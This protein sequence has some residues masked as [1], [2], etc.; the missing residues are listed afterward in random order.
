LRANAASAAI[1][2]TATS[3]HSPPRSDK[4]ENYDIASK[5]GMAFIIEE[6]GG[7]ATDGKQDLMSIK[8]E[9]LN[10]RCPI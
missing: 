8:V 1:S 9:E 7:M 2:E 4:K 5:S 10:Q 3:G 6:T